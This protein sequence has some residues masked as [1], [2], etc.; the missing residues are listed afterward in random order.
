MEHCLL[1]NQA[2]I[3]L[4]LFLVIR[5]I[6]CPKILNQRVLA[7]YCRYD[8]RK[9]ILTLTSEKYSDRE[10]NRLHIV[11]MV[12]KLVDEGHRAHPAV[13]AAAVTMGSG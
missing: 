3:P 12:H 7:C 6:V 1:L 8:P 4:Q 5:G 9:G 10:E 11:E 13:E 2:G